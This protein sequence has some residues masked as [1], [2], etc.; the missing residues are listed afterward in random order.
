MDKNLY[1]TQSLNVAAWLIH[2]DIEFKCKSIDDNGKVVFY[3]ERTPDT[4]LAVDEYNSNQ[5]I[6]GFITA[7]RKVKNIM[8]E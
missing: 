3:F 2:R 1:F 6:R 4:K 8:K 7:F 5:E